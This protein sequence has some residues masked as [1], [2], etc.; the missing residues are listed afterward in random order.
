MTK[1]P[2]SVDEIV[3]LLSKTSIPTLLVE[4]TDDFFI[5]RWIESKLSQFG[6]DILPCSGRDPLLKVYSRRAEYAQS[7]VAFIADRDMWLFTSIPPEYQDIIWTDGYSIENDLYEPSK[8]DDLLLPSESSNMQ[9]L[10]SELTNWFAFEVEE[11]RSNRAAHVATHPN[12]IVKLETTQLCADFCIERGYIEP[13]LQTIEEIA[14]N[15]RLKIRGK[16]LFQLLVRY[17]SASSRNPKYSIAQLIDIALRMSDNNPRLNR[18]MLEAQVQ[19][20]AA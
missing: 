12:K 9:L 16:N 19:L 2:L 1:S 17:L 7:N 14:A 6:I 4:G 8:L 18:I 10:L 13:S 15:Y 5:Y 3:S 11:F 20:K